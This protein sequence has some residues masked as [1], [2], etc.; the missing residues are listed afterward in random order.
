MNERKVY[1]LLSCYDCDTWVINVYEHESDAIKERDRIIRENER[2]DK[3]Y[4]EWIKITNAE[5]DRSKW[6]ECTE[7]PE[8]YD[9][10]IIVKEMPLL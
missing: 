4:K 7:R 5:P 3:E 6:P 1:L 2:V 8:Y 9:T 10:I